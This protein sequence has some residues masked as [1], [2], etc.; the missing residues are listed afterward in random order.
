MPVFSV[1]V[2]GHIQYYGT[3]EML[4]TRWLQTYSARGRPFWGREN[5]VVHAVVLPRLS[6]WMG[7]QPSSFAQ[8]PY[9]AARIGHGWAQAHLLFSNGWPCAPSG[10]EQGD[11]REC[12]QV[13]NARPGGSL[14]GVTR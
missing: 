2:Y 7:T 11:P 13:C 9:S 6:S 3:T 5:P 4:D 1:L 14:V 8:G 10:L 12:S